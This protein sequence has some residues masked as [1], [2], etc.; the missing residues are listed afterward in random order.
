MTR[1][2]RIEQEA[3][4]ELASA[5]GWY[6]QQRAG[7]GG[8]L[9]DAVNEA[10]ARILED[11]SISIPVPGRPADASVRRIF[12]RR[13][14]YAIVFTECVEEIQVVAVAHLRR[15]PGYWRSRTTR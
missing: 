10:L 3:R 9:L 1:R 5:V 11:P 4:E 8:E 6:E 14:P 13:F 12:V 7:L 2:L 15:R